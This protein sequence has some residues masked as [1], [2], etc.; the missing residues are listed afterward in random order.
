MKTFFIFH[1]K[2][3]TVFEN[4]EYRIRIPGGTRAFFGSITEI[5]VTFTCSYFLKLF[6]SSKSFMFQGTAQSK[7]IINNFLYIQNAFNYALL[8]QRA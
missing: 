8:L 1:F 4:T 6:G 3:I 5:F 7:N 2:K